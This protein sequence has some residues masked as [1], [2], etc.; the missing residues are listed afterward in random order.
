M[1]KNTLQATLIALGIAGGVVM[2]NTIIDLDNPEPIDEKTAPVIIEKCISEKVDVNGLE[3]CFEK[4]VYDFVKPA[5][6]DKFRTN[7]G[8]DINDLPLHIGVLDNEIQKDEGFRR[9]N[10]NTEDPYELF[11]LLTNEYL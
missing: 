1:G 4:I 3:V 6:G 11:V 7:G 5:L 2:G 9:E 8:V 10:Y